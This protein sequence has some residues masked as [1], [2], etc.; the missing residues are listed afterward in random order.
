[1][2][3]RSGFRSLAGKSPIEYLYR[4][5]MNDHD[6]WTQS[7]ATGRSA[8]AKNHPGHSEF[9]LQTCIQGKVGPISIQPTNTATSQH[10][11]RQLCKFLHI[12]LTAES[13]YHAHSPFTLHRSSK[14]QYTVKVLYE[15]MLIWGTNCKYSEGFIICLC[16]TNLSPCLSLLKGI[17]NVI[18]SGW[19]TLP[20]Q[21]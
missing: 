5:P 8:I 9:W 7:A 6:F 4:R 20:K 18:I 16:G 21:T 11:I 15:R 3:K 17:T 10:V 14:V 2:I 19:L 12:L 13:S 1:M